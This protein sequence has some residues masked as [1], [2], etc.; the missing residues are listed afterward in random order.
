MKSVAFV[1]F[2]FSIFACERAQIF[3]Q[4]KGIDTQNKQITDIGNSK[5][6]TD[7]GN[8]R[9]VGA[10]RGFDFGAGKTPDRLPLANPYRMA[11]K[12]DILLA[13]ITD[14]LRNRNLV[15]DEAAS[16]P[17][18]GVL[19]T[20]PY[21][22]SKGAVI[23]QSQL[24]RY[25]TLPDEDRRDGVW[26]RARYTLTIDVQTIDGINNNVSITAKVEGRTETALGSQ[27]LTLASSGEVENDVLADLVERVTG[28]APY[29]VTKQPEKSSEKQSEKS[30]EK[31][32]KPQ[33]K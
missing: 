8:R 7:N 14:I 2:L 24:L 31:S 28:T 16:R 15:L 6:P 3:A 29:Q 19:V 26:T 17:A 20:Q 21:T 22:F 30:P 10:G 1:F 33:M 32:D 23:T 27:W 12:R 25:A 18:D 4:A 11:S 5:G 9:D 13:S